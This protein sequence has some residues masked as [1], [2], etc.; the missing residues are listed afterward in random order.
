[1]SLARSLVCRF[2]GMARNASGGPL[3]LSA[4]LFWTCQYA[5]LLANIW[6]Y[7]R[8]CARRRALRRARSAR[9]ASFYSREPGGE[10]PERHRELLITGGSSVR[11]W[12]IGASSAS[13][14]NGERAT[15]MCTLAETSKAQGCRPASLHPPSRQFPVRSQPIPCS[16][17]GGNFAATH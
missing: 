9:V 12:P 6:A 5:G 14:V 8:D 10:N 17:S 13:D 16:L 1:M 4:R 2:P 3:L 15:A 7:V 11:S